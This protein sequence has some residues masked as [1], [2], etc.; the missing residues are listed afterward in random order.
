MFAKLTEILAGKH[1][2]AIDMQIILLSNVVYLFKQYVLP[3]TTG[4]GG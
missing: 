4:N 1:G 2:Y 3:M